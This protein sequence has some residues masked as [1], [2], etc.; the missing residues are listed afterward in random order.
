MAYD[1]SSLNDK[2]LEQISRDL[3]NAELS[4]DLQDFKLEETRELT[5]VFQ[6]TVI[7]MRL[8]YK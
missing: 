2:E 3:L 8:L 6:Q 7:Q 1:F 4:L 5:S